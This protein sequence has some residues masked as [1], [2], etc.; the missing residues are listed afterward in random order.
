MGNYTMC[1][2]T[3]QPGGTIGEGAQVCMRTA[4]PPETLSVYGDLEPL[5]P[6][7]LPA[8]TTS[9]TTVPPTT[10]TTTTVTPSL[11]IASTSGNS[12]T[13][14]GGT[15]LP[16]YVYTGTQ[17][18]CGCTSISGANINGLV[19]GTYYISDGINVRQ[20]QKP[21]GPGSSMTA[22]GSCVSCGS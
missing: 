15:S 22:T 21:F 4:N 6:C 10:T 1:N 14:T 13:S 17:T 8:T 16:T 12:C 3:Y 20:F 11:Y 2:G 7:A 18:L 5:G 19:D 9:T